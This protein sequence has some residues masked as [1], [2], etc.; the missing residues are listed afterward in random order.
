MNVSTVYKILS[1]LFGILGG[2]IAGALFKQ[3]WKRVSDKDEA[4]EPTDPDYTW[5]QILPPAIVKGAIVGG[6]RA[7]VERS[8]ANGVRRVTGSWPTDD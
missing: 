7:V 3:L 1:A 2:V 6:V 8:G 5:G 4:P